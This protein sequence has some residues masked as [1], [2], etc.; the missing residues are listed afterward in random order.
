V[1]AAGV[2]V[3]GKNGFKDRFDNINDGVMDD[4]ILKMRGGNFSSFWFK[5]EKL[6]VRFGSVKIIFELPLKLRK[7]NF[8]S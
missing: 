3:R 4:P 8:V 1:F 6:M 7:N 5:N 2:G